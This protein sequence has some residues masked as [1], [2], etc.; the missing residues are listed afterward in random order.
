MEVATWQLWG[1]PGGL[2]RLIRR[3]DIPDIGRL[4]PGYLR[5]VG[6]DVPA[7]SPNSIFSPI[8]DWRMSEAVEVD[9][10]R[11]LNRDVAPPNHRDR[12]FDGLAMARIRET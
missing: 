2:D 7:R 4:N 8:W 9:S 5:T 1:E 10:E 11:Y 6:R 3:S 12:I